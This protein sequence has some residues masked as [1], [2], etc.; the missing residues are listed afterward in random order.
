M[1]WQMQ[2]AV[3]KS[4]L[5]VRAVRGASGSPIAVRDGWKNIVELLLD[6][7]AGTGAAGVIDEIASKH[8]TMRV[9]ING[10]AAM[11]D[12]TRERIAD[13]IDL[14]ETRS[15]YHC[16]QCGCEGCL[17]ENVN[18]WLVTACRNHGRGLAVL[19]H[20]NDLVV[21][22]RWIDGRLQIT[23]CRRYARDHDR[24]VDVDPASVGLE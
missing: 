21:R 14:A 18:G 2:M 7:V 1:T 13:A 8:G 9:L 3:E 23:R 5:F 6:E 12:K 4:H 10:I 17:F 16:E 24:F 19:A 20:S 22:R 11:D 15:S